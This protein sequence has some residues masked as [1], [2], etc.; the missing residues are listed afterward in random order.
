M[1]SQKEVWNN[2][3]KPWKTF[4]V[5]PFEEVK[6]FLKNKKGNVLDLGCG[7]GRNFIKINGTIYGIDFSE[8]MLKYAKEYSKKNNFNVKLIKSNTINL[9]FENNFFDAVISVAVLHCIPKAEDREKSLKELFRVLKPN[10]E[11]LITVW[12][13]DQK[14]FKNKEKESLIPWT[15]E[16]KKYMRYYYLYD[17]QEFINLLKNTGFEIIKIM[18]KEYS[19][20]LYSKRNIIAVVKKI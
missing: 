12:D 15:I 19:Q 17:K 18:D 3:A 9:P 11:A 4:R 13:Y 14:R 1:K 5:K 16:G 2:I 6:D 20:G 7:T 10:G 8:E